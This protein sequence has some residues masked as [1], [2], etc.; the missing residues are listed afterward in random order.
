MPSLLAGVGQLSQL[1][2]LC[3]LVKITSCRL[4]SSLLWGVAWWLPGNKHHHESTD[5]EC[6]LEFTLVAWWLPR[7][8]HHHER[9]GV[10]CGLEFNLVAWWLPGNKHHHE[11]T[12]VECCLEFTL[13][14]SISTSAMSTLMPV[15]EPSQRWQDEPGLW[16]QIHC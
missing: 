8:K 9:T 16:R 3:W 14:K 6:G 4:L 2:K 10:E 11:R 5:V 1:A 15:T 12:G 7:N 13:A